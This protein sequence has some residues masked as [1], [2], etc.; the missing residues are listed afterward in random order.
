MTGNE[1]ARISDPEK[2]NTWEHWTIYRSFNPLDTTE[3]SNAKAEYTKLASDWSAAVETF[4]AR[5][6]RSSTSAWEGAATASQSAI[7]DY[8]TRALELT[9]ALNALSQQVTT[10]VNGVNNT[11][12][13][14]GEPQNRPDSMWNLDGYDFIFAEPGSRST[15]AINKARD[16]AREA[17]Q[18]NYVKDFVAAD[19]QI[20]VLPQPENPTS[21][22]TTWKPNGGAFTE[23]G[24][25]GGNGNGTKR[26]VRTA[27]RPARIQRLPKT[28]RLLKIRPTQTIPATTTQPTTTPVHQRQR[29]RARHHLRPPRR[30]P[31]RG[32]HRQARRVLVHRVAV[33]PA[34]VQPAAARA[35]PAPRVAVRLAQSR[36]DGRPRQRK[37]LPAQPPQPAE[38]APAKRAR[39]AWA[40]WAAAGA[41]A[42]PKTTSRIRSRTG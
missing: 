37:P 39:Q 18:N 41:V 23:D 6:R 27:N 4:A 32:S 12:N 8:A 9:P 2:P 33:H 1:K 3:A 22:L 19:G 29:N 25:D 31:R 34:V 7:A 40:A 21:P 5:I 10:T 28:L 30:Q 15:T 38:A 35:A 36:P 24:G 26:R 16:E 14:V 20:P 11:R 13:G 17:M 42:N